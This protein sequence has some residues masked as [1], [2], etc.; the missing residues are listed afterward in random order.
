[1]SVGNH[2]AKRSG[3]Q[4]IETILHFFSSCCSLCNNFL[5]SYCSC[6]VTVVYLVTVV[7]VVSVAYAVTV[8]YVVTTVYVVNIV[9]VVTAVY[10]VTIVW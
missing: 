1:M 3:F 7:C 10:V 5:C 2:D 8:V 6:I 4:L 9:C